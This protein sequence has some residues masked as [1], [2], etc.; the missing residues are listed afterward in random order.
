VAGVG[1]SVSLFLALS[2]VSQGLGHFSSADPVGD[3]GLLDPDAGGGHRPVSSF[4]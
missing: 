3:G 4:K 1:F 2:A